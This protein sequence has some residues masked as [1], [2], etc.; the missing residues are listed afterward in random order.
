MHCCDSRAC[1]AFEA[2]HFLQDQISSIFWLIH[3]DLREPKFFRAFECLST[4]V[5]SVEPA[6]VDSVYEEEIPGNMSFLEKN[7]SNAKFCVRLKRWNGGVKHLE[8]HVEGN[9]VKFI[10]SPSVQF[11][12]ELSEKEHSDRANVVLPFEHQEIA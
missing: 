7:Y 6:I 5:A 3:L 12:L 4:M 2:A 11:N 8:L 10:S 9:D 1:K